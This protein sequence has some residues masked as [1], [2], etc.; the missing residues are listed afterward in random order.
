M[1]RKA[2]DIS[3]PNSTNRSVANRCAGLGQSLP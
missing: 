3:I 2:L 1:I